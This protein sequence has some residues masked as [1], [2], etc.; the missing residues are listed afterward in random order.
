M[1]KQLFT[2]M[3]RKLWSAWEIRVL[4]LISLSLQI[5]LN[6]FG[7]RRKYIARSWI[8]ILVW[9][10]YL[11]ADWVATVALGNLATNVQGNCENSSPTASHELQEFWAPFLLFHLGGPDAITAYSLEDNELWLRHFL[12]FVV[13]LGVTIYVYVQSWS[14]INA[15]TFLSIPV[16]IVGFIKYGERTWVFWSSSTE[17]LRDTLLAMVDPSPGIVKFCMQAGLHQDI[18]NQEQKEGKHE[19]LDAHF[20]FK[21]FSRLF[22][23]L[24]LSKGE[25]QKTIPYFYKKPAKEAFNLVAIELGFMYD[26]L[27]TKLIIVY[28]R[29]GL[30]L[31]YFNFLSIV[32]TLVVFSILIHIN[33]YPYY[34][35][36]ICITYCLILGAFVM[37][38]FGFVHYSFNDWAKLIVLS[39]SM[40]AKTYKYVARIPFPSFLSANQK[41][42]SMS[43]RQFNLLNFCIKDI[44]TM[45]RYLNRAEKLLGIL[46]WLEK[47][48]YL[49]WEDVNPDLQEIIY[50][51]IINAHEDNLPT[52]P[53]L[54]DSEK[55]ILARRG[56]HVIKKN[57]LDEE[58]NWYTS[59]CDFDKSILAW[60]IATDL[61]YYDDSTKHGEADLNSIN[62]KTSRCLSNYML[63][64]LVFCPTMMSSGNGE[65]RYRNACDEVMRELKLDPKDTTKTRSEILRPLFE[66]EPQQPAHVIDPRYKTVLSSARSLFRSLQNVESNGWSFEKKWEMICEVWVEM[67]GYA[68]IHCGWREHGQQLAKGGELLTHVCL[69]MTHLGLKAQYDYDYIALDIEG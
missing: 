11:A 2:E 53:R 21:R 25:A 66:E 27:F 49:T 56:D 32:T 34:L 60:H 39:F 67:L 31:H 19:L 44:S 48:Q 51:G 1:N 65:L 15:L 13:Q 69:I 47:F 17:R 12:Q 29:L 36:D 62:C 4:V 38:I 7:S 33:S 10:S 26:F 42:W 24:M 16:I 20:L 45:Y 6:F 59:Q 57:N 68:A 63:Y 22:T 18:E 43:M 50:R 3:V 61:C 35:T 23:G 41:R 5:I 28:H 14:N 58:G 64:L 55:K 46:N 30:F 52:D 54:R 40:K 8:K 37:E 9:S